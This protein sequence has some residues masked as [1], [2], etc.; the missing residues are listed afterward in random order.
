MSRQDCTDS[1]RSTVAVWIGGRQTTMPSSRCAE[2]RMETSTYVARHTLAGKHPIF[3]AMSKSCSYSKSGRR[4]RA[5]THARTS[6]GF[7]R[8]GGRPMSSS[9]ILFTRC[10]HANPAD[11]QRYVCRPTI[12]SS[13]I[14]NQWWNLFFMLATCPIHNKIDIIIDIGRKKRK[15]QRIQL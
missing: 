10:V 3:R 8:C 15:G 14:L 4:T 7:Y 11:T 1:Y 5:L 2:P 12:C 9:L 6:R 13:C